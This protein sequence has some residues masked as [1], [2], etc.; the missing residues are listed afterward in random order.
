MTGESQKVEKSKSR[1]VDIP[2]HRFAWDGFSFNI[3]QTWNLSYYH[4]DKHVSNIRM[5][6]DAAIRLEMEWTRPRKPVGVSKL[7][8]RYITMSKKLNKHA[9][10][11]RAIEN[12]PKGWS[13][14]LNLMP[15][16]RGLLTSF[17][18][19]SNTRFFCFLRIHFNPE[20]NREPVHVIRCLAS[21]FKT[22]ENHCIPWEFYDVSLRLSKEFRL[23]NT[24]LE[25]GRKLMV[26]QWRLRK[27]YLWQ[28]SLADI[29][30]KQKSLAAWGAEFLN[31]IKEIQGVRF[32]P[33]DDQ[34][35]ETR[36]SR[37]YPFGHYDEIGRQCFLYQVRCAHIPEK[38]A[39]IL[40]VYNYRS[41][42]DLEKIKEFYSS[43]FMI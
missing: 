14:F 10:K 5:E 39:V 42:S 26:F 38:N 3:P 24:S 17:W 32:L 29:L 19:S 30:L 27:L 22:Y 7:R 35:I 23:V 43:V 11:V 8:E 40:V 13:A 31:N 33:K 21:S 12:L 28:F 2:A 9:E 37:K 41:P 25:A 18:L 20:E 1:K 4:F 36:R 15:D 34:A 6:D 16:K